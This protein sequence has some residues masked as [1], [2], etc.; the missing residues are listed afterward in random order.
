MPV[1]PVH[2][3]CAVRALHRGE[4]IA[5]PTEAVWGLGCDPF[6][7][8]AVAHLLQI[9]SRPVHKGM[10]L[11]AADRGQLAPL[12]DELTPAQNE[13]LDRTWPGPVTWLLPD[14]DRLVPDW[15]RGDHDRVAVRVSAH[16]LVQALCRGFGGPIVSTSANRA[17]QRPARSRLE[18]AARLGGEADFILPGCLG[19]EARPSQ[20]RDLLSD[21][22][23]R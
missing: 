7:A 16:P 17:G 23:L 1:N 18:L 2:L 5:Y 9:K 10:I 13:R 19:G 20:I 12:L 14:P 6:N 22:I 21:E 4:V 15:V 11:V 8:D 3:H